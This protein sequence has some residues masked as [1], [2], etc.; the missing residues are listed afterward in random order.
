MAT[1]NDIKEAMKNHNE[2]FYLVDYEFEWFP[3]SRNNTMIITPLKGAQITSMYVNEDNKLHAI[4]KEER[5]K[6]FNPINITVKIQKCPAK[7]HYTEYTELNSDFDK[8][9]II[10]TIYDKCGYPQYYV[11]K[12]MTNEY[13]IHEYN[14]NK[15]NNLLGSIF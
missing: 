10:L 7:D 1:I 13:W 9:K 3:V 6:E 14:L 8:D 12:D 5:Y 15:T 11:Y 4:V 2:G